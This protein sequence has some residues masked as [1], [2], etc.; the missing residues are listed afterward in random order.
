MSAS[1]RYVLLLQEASH[2]QALLLLGDFNHPDICWKSS[3]VSCRQSRKLLEYIEDNFLSQVTDSPIRGYVILDLMVTNASEL[4]KDIKIGGSL[5]CS[6]HA[7]VEFTVL[8]EMDQ[9]TSKVRTLNFRKANFQLFKE[10]VNRTSWEKY[11][12]T[13]WLC[14]DR[15]RK[16]KAWLELNLARNNKGFYRHIS[17]KRKV[18]ESVPPIRNM[19]G[20][21]VTMDEEKAE[22]LNNFFASVFTGN[23]SSYN[24]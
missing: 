23:L 6:D 1:T 19:T 2:S 24:S 7:L 15:I 14:R 8:R 16:A 13:A 9:A 21:L 12:D 17:Q 20:K 22:V 4:M 11:R 18:K 10:L 3:T 5:G